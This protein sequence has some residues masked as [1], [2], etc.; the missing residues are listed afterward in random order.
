M[1]RL[2][3]SMLIV[4]FSVTFVLCAVVSL[5]AVGGENA[6]PTDSSEFPWYVMNKI[7]DMYRGEKSNAVMTMQVKTKHWTRS[8]EMEAWSLGKDYS[9]VRIL[10]PRKEKGSATL[11]AKK[12]L[13]TY[14]NKTGRTIKITSGMMGASWMGSH[15]TNDDLVK[16]SRLADDYTIELSFNGNESGQTLYR[17]TLTPKPNSPVVWGK[18][19]ITVRQ[20]DLQPLSQTF[21]D[22]DGKKMRRLDFSGHKKVSGR[23]IPTKMKMTPLDKPDEYTEIRYKK[24]DFGAKLNKD[25]FSIQKLKSL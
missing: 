22:E 11:K 10:K 4:T 24:I 2:K 16:D 18:V 25:F 15:F 13:F 6:P 7:D 3:P 12:N 20:A 8:L 14:L 9:L 21:Y 5:S 19:T 1:T 23:V 17:F